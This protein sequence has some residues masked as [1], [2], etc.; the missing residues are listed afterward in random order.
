MLPFLGELL[1]NPSS[2]HREGQQA[3]AAI[4]RSRELVGRFLSLPSDG[5]LVF[6]SGGTEGINL[7]IRGLALADRPLI[8]SAVEHAAVLR[9]MESMATASRSFQTI[10]V[11]SEGR[12]LLEELK[13]SMPPRALVAV[14]LANNETGTIQ[15]IAD[16]AEIV[17]ERE[18]LLL[19]DA[20]QAAGRLPLDRASWNALVVSAHKMGGPK[21]AGALALQPGLPFEAIMTGGPQ[22]G[23]LRAGTENTAAIAG[24]A[25]AV[26]EV[27]RDL[28]G[29]IRRLAGLRD[30]LESRLLRA[31]PDCRV[32]GA[33]AERVP[34]TS[35]VLVPGIRGDRLAA[36]LDLVGISISTGT[37]CASGA[38]EPSHVAAALGLAPEDRRSLLRFS[39][40]MTNDER[41]VDAAIDLVETVIR[42][43]RGGR[44]PG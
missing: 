4:E 12:I 15:P 34:N 5:R 36:A 10:P 42:R 9:T 23:T 29:R 37:A 7:A 6:T 17:S 40:G 2:L 24:F 44:R 43:I 20:V 22:E 32:I 13:R 19:V 28:S 35:L 16:V 41:E 21:G 3:R 38:A 11:D 31:Q 33:M 26:L 30:R 39:V 27:S 18:G 25:A 8:A 14:M 1:G